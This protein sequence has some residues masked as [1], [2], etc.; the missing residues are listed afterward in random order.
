[1]DCRKRIDIKHLSE[2]VGT[3]H[4]VDQVVYYQYRSKS[5]RPA[6]CSKKAD[7]KIY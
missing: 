2:A 7:A 1:M 5:R 6:V 4:H 3:T